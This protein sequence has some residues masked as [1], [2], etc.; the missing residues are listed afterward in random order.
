MFE[1]GEETLLHFFGSN[2]LIIKMKV[3]IRPLEKAKWHG[4]SGVDDFSQPKVIEALVN[5]VTNR[6]DTG[7]SEEETVKYS[8]LLGENLSPE[9]SL[10]GKPHPFYGMKKC[11]ILFPIK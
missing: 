2:Q 8:R 1:S 11:W 7:L 3:E 10:D 6:Y 5:S 4:K 9:I